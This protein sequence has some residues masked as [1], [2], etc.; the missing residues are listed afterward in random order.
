MEEYTQ[1]R[2]RAAQNAILLACLDEHPI[3]PC[4]TEV[5][6]NSECYALTLHREM[7]LADDLASISSMKYDPNRV[8]AI[9]LEANQNGAGIVFR[10]A[11]N[12]GSLECAVKELQAIADIMM[13][14]SKHSTSTGS[15]PMCIFDVH[16][17]YL[18]R[19]GKPATI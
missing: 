8:T 11:S 18:S 3:P 16:D 7:Q 6:A 1:A 10:I 12:T 2:C 9:C 19:R 14:A 13:Q 15:E 5:V 4:E 17:R